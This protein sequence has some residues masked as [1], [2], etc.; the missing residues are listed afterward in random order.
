MRSV[1][2]PH[3]DNWISADEGLLPV[4]LPASSLVDLTNSTVAA[5]ANCPDFIQRLPPM[6][7]VVVTLGRPGRHVAAALAVMNYAIIGKGGSEHFGD[8]M[9]PPRW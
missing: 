7:T 4:G 5:R 8:G 2:P 3:Y 6:G 1:S 9:Y